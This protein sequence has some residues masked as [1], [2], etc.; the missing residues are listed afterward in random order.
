MHDVLGTW[1]STVFLQLGCGIEN[2]DEGES[3]AK[4]LTTTIGLSTPSSTWYV[5]RQT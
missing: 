3:Y 4:M 1:Y 5:Y 2:R